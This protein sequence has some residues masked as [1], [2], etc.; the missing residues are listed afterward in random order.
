MA[1]GFNHINNRHINSKNRLLPREIRWNSQ[2]EKEMSSSCGRVN[3]Y[4]HLTNPKRSITL[5]SLYTCMY[6]Q[7]YMYWCLYIVDIDVRMWYV[8][9][10]YQTDDTGYWISTLPPPPLY[11]P[12]SLAPQ[13]LEK[14]GIFL[15]NKQR[16]LCTRHWFVNNNLIPQLHTASPYDS[17]I[18][19]QFS[20][21][22]FNL[23]KIFI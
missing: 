23:L 5:W 21:E 16:G 3:S 9:C 7:V 11:L 13:K 20:Y 14:F 1:L 10:L 8:S 22:V 19:I 4:C 15:L 17:V 18:I 2:I 12:P 6:P